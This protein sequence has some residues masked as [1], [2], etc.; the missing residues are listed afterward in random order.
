MYKV[1]QPEVIVGIGNDTEFA[2][3]VAPFKTV[4]GLHIDLEDWL[5]DDLMECHPCYI[6]TEDLK[7]GLK[8]TAFSGYTIS[9]LKL[10]KSEYFADNYSVKKKLPVFYWFKING[11]VN[12]DDVYLGDGRSLFLS[13]K[14]IKYLKENFTVKY[15]EIDPQRNEFDDLLDQMIA[16]SKK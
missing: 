12:I 3:T 2:E 1:V 13:E 5:G 7:N 10:T 4:N 14:F 11:K 9:E 16:D 6:I 8:K 15:L